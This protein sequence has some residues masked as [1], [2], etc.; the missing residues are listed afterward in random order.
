M[1]SYWEPIKP[2]KNLWQP[3]LKV[4]YFFL[5][6]QAISAVCILAS[7][8]GLAILASLMKTI[9]DIR[10]VLPSNRV[11]WTATEPFVVSGDMVDVFMRDVIT[12]LYSRTEKGRIVEDL[13]G[14]VDPVILELIDKPFA[15]KTQPFVISTV[16]MGSKLRAGAQASFRVLLTSRSETEYNA[17][18]VFFDTKWR[19]VEATKNNPIGWMLVGLAITTENL[20]NREEILQEVKERTA[21]VSE[22]PLVDSLLPGS[23]PAGDGSETPSTDSK[24]TIAVPDLGVE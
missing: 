2:D 8:A 3:I 14:V 18:V 5:V 17:S 19:R 1:P 16:V 4:R 9:P 23:K 15:G 6:R 21:I 13:S 10:I 24:A 11:L 7:L 12:A 20:Y 22:L